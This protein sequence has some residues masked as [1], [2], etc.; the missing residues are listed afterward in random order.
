MDLFDAIKGRRS[1]RK[2]KSGAVEEAKVIEMLRAGMMA[3]SAGN[4]RPWHFVVVDSREVLD[5]I[6]AVHPHA[7]ML[8]GA[9]MA[10]VVCADRNSEKHKGYWVQDCSAAVENML[11]AAHALGLGACWLGVFPREDRVAGIQKLLGTPEGV[12]PLAAIAV[13]C[14]AEAHGPVDRFDAARIHRN[15]W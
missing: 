5:G 9:P 6:M 1:V 12:V 11:L 13:G 3:P 10:I 4:Q 15:R 2:F 7:G 8:K 14:P